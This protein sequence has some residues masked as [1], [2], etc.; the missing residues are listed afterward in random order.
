MIAYDL[1]W[2]KLKKQLQEDIKTYGKAIKKAGKEKDLQAVL[3]LNS[4]KEGLEHVLNSL[5]VQIEKE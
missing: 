2:Q 5:I 3:T 1:A 4:E